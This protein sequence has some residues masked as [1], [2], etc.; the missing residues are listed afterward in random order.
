MSKMLFQLGKR[1]VI[2]SQ[3]HIF[4]IRLL[5]MM[6]YFS[7]LPRKVQKTTAFC[8]KM[9]QSWAYV[10]NKEYTQLGSI[11]SSIFIF[12]LNVNVPFQPKLRDPAFGKPQYFFFFFLSFF[13][14]MWVCV[15]RGGSSRTEAITRGLH[16]VGIK[17][18]ISFHKHFAFNVCWKLNYKKN[19]TPMIDLRRPV[20]WW[21]NV[22]S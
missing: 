20:S 8:C 22:V 4:F 9:S 16:F 21:W 10:K 11:T 1:N 2:P 17:I 6:H 19:K 14:F 12:Q 13:F 5:F 3:R 18:N 7:I 15:G